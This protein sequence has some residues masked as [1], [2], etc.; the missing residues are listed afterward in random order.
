MATVG[1]YLKFNLKIGLTTSNNK[2]K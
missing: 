1:S 2:Q